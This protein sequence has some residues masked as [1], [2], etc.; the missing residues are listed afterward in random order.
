MTTDKIVSTD[1]NTYF[2]L[3]KG[4]I[5]GKIT[6]KSGSSGLY[7]LSEWGD[8]NGLITQAQNTANAAVESAKN[9]NTAVGNLNDYVDGAF[10]DGI[11]E[12]SEAKAIEKYINTV[13]NTK[14]AVEAAYNKLYT[15]AYLTGTAKTGLL[16]AKVTLMAVLKTLSAQ[17]IPLSPMVEPP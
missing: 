9:A 7:E 15:N 16:N 6:F 8:V 10:A 14:A 17:S 2:D 1:G 11:I 3:L 4:I 13:N 5:S 12:E